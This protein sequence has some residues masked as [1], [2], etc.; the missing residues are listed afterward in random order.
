MNIGGGVISVERWEEIN[1][2]WM[3]TEDRFEVLTQA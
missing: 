2:R 3:L 1:G